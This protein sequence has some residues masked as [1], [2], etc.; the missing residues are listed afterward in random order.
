M[1]E[2][3]ARQNLHE[4]RYNQCISNSSET[5]IYGYSWYLD[6]V[7]EQW[8]VL[9]YQ[10][11]EA[12]MPLP[13]NL[14]LGLKYITQPFFCQQLGIYSLKEID[15]SLIRLFFTS[16]P[17]R[18]LRINLNT[19]VLLD[20]Q[21]SKE[22][23]NYILDLNKEYE[24]IFKGYRKDRKKSLRKS[25]DA[26]LSYQD[27]ENKKVL[28]DL[29]RKVFG[30]LYISEKYYHTID[31]VIDETF[32]RGNGFIRNVFHNE[33]LICSGF[34]VHF[35]DRIY[36]LFGAS[37]PQGKKVGATTFLIDSVIKQFASTATIFDFEGSNIDS[38]ASFYKSF[39][40]SKMFYHKFSS[41]VIKGTIL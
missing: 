9:I 5:R 12:V 3:V 1:I 11:Y 32:K 33:E 7:C 22:Q 10:N 35:N 31:R 14:K 27:F 17:T 36:Y 30:H 20:T 26:F 19:N 40:S 34:F 25:V 8:G 24:L 15:E 13:W 6:L 16:I 4:E 41:N 23:I 21:K 29:Y 37:N 18:F 2:Y 38:I 39:G 28:V